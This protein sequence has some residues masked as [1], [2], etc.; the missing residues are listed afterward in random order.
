MPQNTFERNHALNHMPNMKTVFTAVFVVWIQCFALSQGVFAQPFSTVQFAASEYIVEDGADVVTLTLERIGPPDGTASVD[1]QTQDGSAFAGTDYVAQGGNLYF[2]TETNI[3]ITVPILTNNQ[4]ACGRRFYVRL[5]NPDPFDTEL[6]SPTV[7]T[8]VIRPCSTYWFATNRVI[9]NENA[10]PV[11]FNIE[12]SFGV[13]QSGGVY[14]RAASDWSA[15]P[16]IDY[17]ETS[18]F[19][20]FAPGETN[21]TVLVPILDNVQVDGTRRFG[22]ALFVIVVEEVGE[23]RKLGFDEAEVI[24]YDDDCGE[25]CIR[26]GV[27]ESAVRAALGRTNWEAI[28]VAELE[29]LTYL[30]A[31]R[32]LSGSKYDGIHDFEGLQFAR[33]LRSLKLRGWPGPSFGFG[34]GG[35]EPIPAVF[36]ADYS[37]LGNL[38]QLTN[39]DLSFNGLTNLTLPSGLTN[40]LTLNLSANE[41]DD[42][43]LPGDLT[44]L[45]ELH[46]GGDYVIEICLGLCTKLLRNR[47]IDYFFLTNFPHLRTLTIG[48]TSLTNFDFGG[49]DIGLETLDLSGN[50]LSNVDFLQRC[51]ELKW[52][53]LSGNRLTDSTDFLPMT[54]LSKLDVLR[55][56]SVSLWEFTLPAALR[57]LSH[58]SMSSNGLYFLNLP[59]D[60]TNL[61]TLELGGN[62]LGHF[63][64]FYFLNGL[65][66]L[67]NLDL[68]GNEVLEF[69]LPAA[70]KGLSALKLGHNQIF[71]SIALSGSLAGMANLSVLGLEGNGLP[72]FNIPAGTSNLTTLRM[73]G[74]QLSD[75]STW[76]ALPL[77]TTLDLSDNRFATISIPPTFTNLTS[78]DLSWNQLTNVSLPATLSHL[79]TLNLANNQLAN[80][81]LPDGLHWLETLDVSRNPLSRLSLPNGLGRLSTVR[82]DGVPYDVITFPPD[83]N[84]EARIEWPNSQRKL[85]V[86]ETHIYAS[87]GWP[88]LNVYPLAVSL[89]LSRQELNVASSITLNGP[90]G[91]YTV[92]GSTNLI[93][94]SDWRTATNELGQV[95]VSGSGVSGDRYFF[96]ARRNP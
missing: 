6:G 63:G 47:L 54:R 13:N 3:A 37:A 65:S 26:D 79:E 74:N 28:T 1:F 48:N 69:Q 95:V 32:G 87:Y 72:A 71:D 80:L 24:I 2:S 88:F 8:V 50:Q 42:L 45:T 10:G 25:V 84:P 57:D 78:L 61:V 62:Y 89:S 15:L 59:A 46:L 18:M 52:L 56:N 66:R 5:S 75:I 36:T 44:Q 12:R 21:K 49:L 7:A 90:P 81:H 53:D 41:L 70:L 31:S 60:M 20:D 39:L 23:S 40:L 9:V 94:W 93:D 34:G 55:M 92:L 91:I 96:R 76:P 51:P 29:S 73:S 85:V 4:T 33:N 19:V 27:L 68:T 30:D 22:A 11:A 43:S 14:F 58:L 38:N 77:L 35:A 16:G 83:I 82:V 67:A 86:P 64:D 17:T